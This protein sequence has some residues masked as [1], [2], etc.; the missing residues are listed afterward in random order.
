MARAVIGPLYNAAGLRR[1]SGHGPSFIAPHYTATENFRGYKKSK[2]G[3]HS[4]CVDCLRACNKIRDA[5]RLA[6]KDPGVMRNQRRHQERLAPYDPTVTREA[7]W[8]YSLGL[9]HICLQRVP[10]EHMTMEHVVPLC[11]GG[12]WTWDNIRPAHAYCNGRKGKMTMQE[13]EE[14]GILRVLRRRQNGMLALTNGS[15]CGIMQSM[16]DRKEPK[17]EQVDMRLNTTRGEIRI[18]SDDSGQPYEME[19]E[20]G[21]VKLKEGE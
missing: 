1:C 2:D 18:S 11:L 12:G 13:M 7:V 9:C 6:E 20:D 10:F 16:D 8:A 3:L 19:T 14:R 5:R 4:M 21:V 17:D 15:D